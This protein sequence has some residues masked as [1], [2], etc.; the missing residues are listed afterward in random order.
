MKSIV[1]A[2]QA[3]EEGVD[4]VAITADNCLGGWGWGVIIKHLDNS[5]PD[6]KARFR[7]QDLPNHSQMTQLQ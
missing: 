2:S 4:A 3:F 1:A 5:A 7:L 6:Y